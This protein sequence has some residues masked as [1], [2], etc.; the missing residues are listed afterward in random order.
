MV[1]VVIGSFGVLGAVRNQ[2][3]AVNISKVNYV[4]N[5]LCENINIFSRLMTP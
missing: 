4:H 1:V 5:I 2:I 3:Q